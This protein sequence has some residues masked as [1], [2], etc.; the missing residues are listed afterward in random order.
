MITGAVMCLAL[1][2]YHEAPHQS[3]VEQLA[4]SFVVM[5]RVESK[6]YPNT[7]CDVI[8]QAKFHKSN[9]TLPIRNACQFSWFCN[10]IG[11][12]PTNMKVWDQ[13]QYVARLVVHGDVPNFME[14]AEHYH[15][16]Y[17]YPSW[18]VN[19][20]DKKVAQIGAHIFYN[21]EE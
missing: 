20:V 5:N 8:Y 10:G 2:L 18:G 14:G 6:R 21:L 4:V 13:A 11:D 7:V 12:V 15:A 19:N 16:T 9:P 3:L 1:N 17:V